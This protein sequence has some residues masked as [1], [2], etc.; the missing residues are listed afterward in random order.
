MKKLK[1][2]IKTSIVCLAWMI[3]TC[4]QKE[5]SILDEQ[6]IEFELNL[7]QENSGTLLKCTESTDLQKAAKIIMTI[8]TTSGWYIGITSA[9][10]NIQNIGDAYL[11]E[12]IMLKKG[13]YK[14]KEFMI[15]DSSGNIIYAAPTEGTNLGDLVNSPLPLA[16]CVGAD[17]NKKIQVEV[18]NTNNMTPEDFG[19][20]SFNIIS[21]S[22]FKFPVAV[23]D[24]ETGD[25]LAATIEV[26]NVDWDSDVSTHELPFEY[27]RD[28][29]QCSTKT[30]ATANNLVILDDTYPTYTIKI[31]KDG[32]TSFSY[33]FT[34]DSLDQYALPGGK[35][36]L[37]FEI[38]STFIDSITDIDGNIYKIIKIGSQVW[39]QDNLFATR[40]NNGVPLKSYE[41][42]WVYSGDGHPEPYR[43]IEVFYYSRVMLRERNICPKGWHVPTLEEWDI[44]INFLGGPDVAGGKLKG[45]DEW[46]CDQVTL[47]CTNYS[48]RWYKMDNISNFY[49]RPY[50]PEYF[51]GN[52][53]LL[54]GG[55]NTSFWAVNKE[56]TTTYSIS[57]SSDS[58]GISY[59]TI[60]PNCLRCIKD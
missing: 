4:C 24:Y 42:E 11:S 57:M 16:F 29:Y 20:A 8:T 30:Q 22:V 14:L 52:L 47:F 51:D 41:S 23:V 56:K 27:G 3:L 10:Y 13:C 49:A 28:I 1:F 55:L 39:M 12:K 36:V 5:E 7:M 6:I 48:S 32:Y 54:F 19:I 44:L 59:G 50:T 53:G 9:E 45:G 58:Y 40:Y 18:I 25:F 35:K 2:W 26:T 31:I 43:G 46:D 33:K 37:K 38:A 17:E 34:K 15:A 60:K 21:P